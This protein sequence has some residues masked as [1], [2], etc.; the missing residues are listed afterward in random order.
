[1]IEASQRFPEVLLVGDARQRGHS[2]GEQLRESIHQVL[3]YYRTLFRL[4][5][6]DLRREATEFGHIIKGFSGEYA[7]E[8]E[9]CAA[10]ANLDA[11]YLY[12]LNSR[13]E[14]LNNVDVAECTAVMHSG[15]ALLAQNWDWSEALEELV[16]LIRLQR[17]DNH[18]ICMLTEPGI[19][20]KIGMNRAGLGVCLNILKTPQRL[21]GLP[22]HV[23]LR[24]LLDCSSMTEARQ[25]VNLVSVGKASHVLVGDASGDVL[26]V[27]FSGGQNLRL[28]PQEDVLLH[29]NH[30]LA[31]AELNDLEAFPSTHER[32]QQAGE[33][34]AA[35]SSSDGIHAMLRD[36]S[37]GEMSICRPYSESATPGFGR[38]GT[39]FTVLM[40]LP[41]RTMNI[42]RGPNA[43]AAN[44]EINSA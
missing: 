25:L 39:V 41:E 33:M 32:L 30:Y 16:V 43:D 31:S 20:G 35:D 13:S 24:A 34:L 29:T 36:Q 23:L 17:P 4:S 8:I 5:D 44:W 27:E 28:E 9:S 15:P 42:Q 6:A 38:V 26:S 19:I 10:A 11:V 18:S 22:V 21:H 1:M 2:H 12:A 7:Q 3:D 37:R 14:I 40:D